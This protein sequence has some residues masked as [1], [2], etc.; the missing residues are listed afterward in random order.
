MDDI[1]RP[2]PGFAE[3]VSLVERAVLVDAG[4][5]AGLGRPSILRTWS[6]QDRFV[7]PPF[8]SGA[9]TDRVRH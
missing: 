9:G 2:L 1:I 8:L 6:N 4:R 3:R 5:E 7:G